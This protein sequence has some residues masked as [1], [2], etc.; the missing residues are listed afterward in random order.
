MFQEA[1]GGI[2][3][4]DEI[5]EAPLSLQAKLLRVLE[6]KE[7]R[8]LGANQSVRVDARVVSAT[9]RPLEALVGASKFRQDL[10]YRL[11][12]IRIEL[13]PLRRRSEDI[14]LLVDHFIRKFARTA[15]R[16][17]EGI[18][19]DALAALK[20]H[21]W[22]GNIRELEHTIERAVL[23]GKESMIGLADLPESFG[24]GSDGAVLID[25]ALTRQLTLHDLERDYIGRVLQA[26]RGNKTEAARILGVDRT[27]LYRKL[28]E[29]K[30]KERS[31]RRRSWHSAD[32]LALEEGLEAFARR[33]G[34]ELALARVLLRVEALAPA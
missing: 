6:D 12:V 29:Y 19:A 8:P 34:F 7:V 30:I 1:S 16:S 3:F 5:G 28:E 4:L 23:L 20:N 15:K 18:Q 21:Q 9:N 17:V 11:N 10:F 22:P 24:A 2:L 32:A 25:Q 31:G 13:P 27:T 26:S 33:V 14:P